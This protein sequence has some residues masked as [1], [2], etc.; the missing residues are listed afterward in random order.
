MLKKLFLITIIAVLA[1]S[2]V[3]YYFVMHYFQN[4]QKETVKAKIFQHLKD[5]DLETISP[6]NPNIYWEEDGKEFL[7]NGQMYDVVKT[8]IVNGREV[9]YCINDKKEK[10]LIDNYNLITKNNSSPDKKAKNSFDNSF[11]LFVDPNERENNFYP[12][13]VAIAYCSFDS[14]LCEITSEQISPPP[15]A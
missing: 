11:N 5:T 10:A 3:G 1:Y 6:S 4:E 15:K 14:Q 12:G 8:K 7:L 13:P 2:Q 9:L